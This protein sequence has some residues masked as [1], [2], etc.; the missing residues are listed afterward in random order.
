VWEWIGDLKP[1][2]AGFLGTLTGSGLGL[3]ALLVGALF[4]AH[5]NRRRDDALRKRETRALG[6]ALRAELSGI[7]ETLIK[8]AGHLVE[9]P[10]AGKEGFVVPD[11]SHAVLAF[12]HMLPNIGLLDESIVRKVMDAYRLTDQYLEGLILLGGVL[13][14]DM[15]NN[16]RAIYLGARQAGA[17]A[18]INKSRAAAI[19]EAIDALDGYLRS[20]KG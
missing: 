17:V 9:N 2:Q 19:Q 10:P 1:S 20:D 12:P 7:Y 16:R 11:L 3:V 15:P 14:D 18:K 4:N 13:R 6:T 8:N 5:L